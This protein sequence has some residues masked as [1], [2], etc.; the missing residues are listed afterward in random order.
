[1]WASLQIAISSLKFVSE[2]RES[3]NAWE[4]GKSGQQLWA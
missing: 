3:W 4:F 1:M 2:L